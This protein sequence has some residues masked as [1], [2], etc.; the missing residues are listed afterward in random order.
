MKGSIG[1]E[2]FQGCGDHRRQPGAL[3]LDTGAV[4][5]FDAFAGTVKTEQRGEDIGCMLAS[6]LTDTNHWGIEHES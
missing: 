4:A 1:H 2:G 6:P 5:S 3:R